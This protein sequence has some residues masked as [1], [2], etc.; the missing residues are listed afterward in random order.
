[1]E[2]IA[3]IPRPPKT[4]FEVFESLPEATLAQ[5]INNQLVISPAPSDTH[6]KVLMDIAT[7][8]YNFLE[9]NPIGVLRI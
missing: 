5:L 1:M 2:A 7:R 3:T 6:Q 9:R 4:M 8:I